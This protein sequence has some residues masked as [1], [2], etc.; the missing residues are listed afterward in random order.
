LLTGELKRIAKLYP[1]SGLLLFLAIAA[2]W[3]ILAGLRNTGGQ[4]GH[5]FFWFYFVNEHILRFLG[6]RTPRD[7]NKLPGWVYWLMHLAWLFPWT[8]FLPLGVAAVWRRFR[9][10]TMTLTRNSNLLPPFWILLLE[11]A[12]AAGAALLGVGV[13]TIGV[14]VTVVYVGFLIAAHRAGV[15]F[16]ASP[17]HRIDPQQ[18]TILLLSLFS[19][20]TLLFFSLS[21]N[22]EY[23]TFPIYLPVLLLIASTITRAE[24]TY[25]SNPEARRW[26]TLAHAALTGIGGSIVLAL[27]YGLWASRQLPYE[28]NVGDLLAHRGVADYTLSMSHLFDLTGRSFAAL[29]LP[30]LLA[31]CTLSLGPAIA[32]MLR[33]QRRHIAATTA[34]A[35]TA[36]GFLFAAQ[37]AFVRFGS[38]L[39]SADFAQRIVTLEQAHAIAPD[40]RIALYGDQANGS[41]IPFYLGRQVD[42]V[43]G[44][45]TSMLF[46]SAFPDAPKLFLTD[47]DLK[48]AWGTGERRILFIPQEFRAHVAGLLG[49][50][51]VVLKESSGKLLVTD[52][53]LDRDL[54]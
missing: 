48:S 49:G 50:Q 21:T 46:G 3:H 28:A 4:D 6:T 47:G 13:M 36:A 18:R 30:A 35:F 31:A 32:W 42:L 12:L 33:V 19:L 53:P 25:S 45:S 2:P 40:S 41:S 15:G 44:R 20:V 11:M 54:H 1:V 22:Q 5:G 39:S 14:L 27:L 9:Y 52:R 43:E 51:W 16:T 34:V 17:F 8:L 10:Q 26:M 24:Q 29:R 23:Y 38:M 37:I 7:F